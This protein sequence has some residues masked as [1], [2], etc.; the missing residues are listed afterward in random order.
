MKAKS[1]YTSA[2]INACLSVIVELITYLHKYSQHLVLIGGWV[3]YFLYNDNKT[4][5]INHVGSLDV[6]LA[7]NFLL[8]PEQDY[9]TIADL[10]Y[11]R[12][13]QNRKDR[14]GK[15]IQASY[16]RTFFDEN[17]IKQTVQVD[18]LAAEYGGSGKK[19]RH[20]K[21][22]EILARKGRGIDLV[23]DDYVERE[24]EARIP[25]GAVNKVN[26]KV[27]NLCSIIASKG[28]AFYER[29]SEKDAYDIYWLFKNHPK[30]DKGII[31]ELSKM[32][33]NKLVSE[34]LG[35]IKER[36]KNL[37]YLGPVAVSDFLE[38]IDDEEREILIRDAYETINRIMKYLQI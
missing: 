13:Y 15:I 16:E 34:S 30:G 12:G 22:Q 4:E 10:L 3:P 19:K 2:E 35:F 37:D 14:K 20:Q 9:Q 17:D 6:D 31:Q 32:K 36:F 11:E 21:I 38:P 5:K 1:Q 26:I 8:I 33:H 18:F 25:N 27:A 24:I 28:F 23:F 7:L 29:G